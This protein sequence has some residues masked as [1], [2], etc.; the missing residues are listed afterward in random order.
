MSVSELP[1]SSAGI[2]LHF[3]CTNCGEAGV[4][5]YCPSCGETRPGSEDMSLGHF[6]G[7]AFHELVHLDSKIFR[8]FVYLLTRPG[9][10]TLEYFQGR[11]KRYITPVRIYIT[12]FALSFFAYSVRSSVSVWDFEKFIAADATGKGVAAIERLLAGTGTTKV[13]FIERVNGQWHK[14]I[15]LT[16]FVNVG[17]VALALQVLYWRSRRY[18]VEHLIF[19][20][21]LQASF[22]LL[23]LVTWPLWWATGME[24][25][26]NRNWIVVATMMLLHAAITIAAV[27]RFYA[28]DRTRNIVKGA[29]T[30]VVT[31]GASV[32]LTL[33]TLF[34]AFYQVAKAVRA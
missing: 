23:S 34:V 31:Y 7:H 32:L 18:F 16:Q 27:W 6:L 20:L 25:T 19:S 13:A 26:T 1:P 2:D 28:Q 24:F 29:L 15:S 10:L 4:R 3:N 22:L 14:L 8:S 17:L 30:Y 33:A 21:H 5:R 11:K 9:F 12:L